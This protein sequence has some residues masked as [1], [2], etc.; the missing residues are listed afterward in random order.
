MR[1]I[2]FEVIIP[3]AAMTAISGAVIGMLAAL[4]LGISYTGYRAYEFF[5]PRYVAVDAKV[6]KESVQYNEGMIRDLSELQRQ[7]QQADTEGKAAL[8][9]IIR[10]R[11]EVYDEGRMPA[12]L[13][14]FY[15]TVK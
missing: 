13:A 11:F 14:A 5:A 3:A 2:F 12:D 7:Y 8:R 1:K 6:Y 15:N 4:A 10:H 9:P